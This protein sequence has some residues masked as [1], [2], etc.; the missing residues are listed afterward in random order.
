MNNYNIHYLDNAFK[1]KYAQTNKQFELMNKIKHLSFD[2][3]ADK[4]NLN[5]ILLH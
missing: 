1:T 3:V 4:N 5:K 2:L